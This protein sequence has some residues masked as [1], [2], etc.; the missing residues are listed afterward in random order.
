MATK[1]KN[2]GLELVKALACVFVV[3]LHAVTNGG[4]LKSQGYLS[5]F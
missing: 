2:D 1:G 3:I 5:T 4:V